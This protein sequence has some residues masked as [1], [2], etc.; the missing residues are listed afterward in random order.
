MTLRRILPFLVCL[1]ALGP[2]SY[3]QEKT[4]AVEIVKPQDLKRTAYRLHIPVDRLANARTALKEATDLVLHA[5]LGSQDDMGSYGTLAGMWIQID[6]KKAREMIGSMILD[7]SSHAQ[8][9]ENLESYRTYTTCAQQLLSSLN[10]LDPERVQQIAQLWPAPSAKFGSAGEADLAR[11]QSNVYNQFASQKAYSNPDM[12]YEQLQQPQRAASLPLA[13]RTQ[14]A[15]GLI[16]SNQKDKAKVLLDQA[17]IEMSSR[18]LANGRNWDYE[19]FLGQL[20]RIYPERMIEA[21][22]AYEAALAR[23][24]ADGIPG[25]VMQSGDQQVWLTPAESTALNVA[26]NIYNR[27]ELTLDL[28]NSVPGFKS[29]IDQLGGLDYVLSPGSGGLTA[30]QQV[31]SY[32]V[33]AADLARGAVPKPVRTTPA[34]QPVQSQSP[35]QLFQS[36]RGKAETNPE[37]VRRKLQ[38]TYRKK[39]DFQLLISLAQVANYQDPDL[40]SIALQVARGLLPQFENLRQRADNLRNLNVD[41][42]FLRGRGRFRPAEAGHGSG[43]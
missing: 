7:L 13:L 36:L 30:N 18:P 17:I 35:N 23:Q 32:P 5:D 21:F 29:K 34:S 10:A 8:A 4:P 40:S 12:I 37:M 9:A 43:E 38:D 16:N 42:A 19:N 3:P 33:T 11:F 6:R 39:E 14:V 15:Q 26:R 41:R 25:L 1:A 31:F 24:S 27:P 2:S 20:A 28:I 22:D